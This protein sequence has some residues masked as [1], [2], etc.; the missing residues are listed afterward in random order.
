MTGGIRLSPPA[1]RA[2][3][4]LPEIVSGRPGDEELQQIQALTVIFA[5][6]P[7]AVIREACGFFLSHAADAAGCHQTAGA[8]RRGASEAVGLCEQEQQA[9]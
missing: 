9:R 7:N 2:G 6:M 5:T 8:C 1:G 3:A 4:G